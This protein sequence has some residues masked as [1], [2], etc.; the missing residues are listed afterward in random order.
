MRRNVLAV[1]ILGWTFASAPGGEFD[2]S[3]HSIDGGGLIKSTGGAF[4][5]SGTI[6]QADAATLTGGSLELTGGFWFE[7]GPTDCNE[8]GVVNRFDHSSFTACLTGPSNLVSVGC[9][10][11]DVD[12]SGTVDLHDFAAA[13]VVSS[14]S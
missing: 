11:F 10:C 13:Q 5:L 12:R 4:E 14:G 7:L 2:L 1:T 6:G 8:D 9:D 3:W